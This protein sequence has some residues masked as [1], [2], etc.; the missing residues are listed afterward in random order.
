M[1]LNHRASRYQAGLLSLLLLASTATAAAPADQAPAS[2]PPQPFLVIIDPGHDQKTRGAT[3]ARGI[4]E[5]ELNDKLAAALLHAFADSPGISAQLSR[6]P[7]QRL[8]LRQRVRR[9]NKA[10]PDLVISLHHDSVQPRF[11]QNWEHDGKALRY[12]DRF[13]GFSIFVPTRGAHRSASQ[14]AATEVA[15]QLHS[16]GRKPSDYH[17]KDIPG[18]RVAWVDQQHG[19]YAGDFLFMIRKVEAPVLLLEA[20][21]IVHRDEERWLVDPVNVEHQARSLAAAITSF[22]AQQRAVRAEQER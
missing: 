17:A 2:L 3:S 7:E 11:L 13:A 6:G 4:A 21:Y 10:S 20:G 19:M 1:R 8:S 18:E 5:V 14:K 12:C 9:I 16:L 15:R 22:A